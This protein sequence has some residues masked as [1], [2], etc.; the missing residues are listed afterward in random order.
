MPVRAAEQRGAKG[1]APAEVCIEK[2]LLGTGTSDPVTTASRD[3]MQAAPCCSYPGAHVPFTQ[4][5][6]TP[7]TEAFQSRPAPVG[8][9]VCCWG[10]EQKLPKA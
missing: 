5:G 9:I 4:F 3:L 8:T 10:P 7:Q 2:H 1:S 6:I